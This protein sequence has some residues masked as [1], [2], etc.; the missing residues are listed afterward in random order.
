MTGAEMQATREVLGLSRNWL[1]ADL[2]ISERRMMRMEA[3]KERIPDALVARLDEVAAHTRD[4]VTELIARYRRETKRAPDTDVLIHTYKADE[5]YAAADDWPG[6]PAR[7]HRMCCARVCEAVPGLIIA[8][9]D[10][11]AQRGP[12]EKHADNVA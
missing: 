4:F 8:Y 10:P 1:S 6:Y 7:W 11:V 2:Q 9:A 5:D 3:D 12:E